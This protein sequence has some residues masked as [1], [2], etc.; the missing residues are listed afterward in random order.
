MKSIN[1]QEVLAYLE[2]SGASY[3]YENDPSP[4]EITRIKKQIK[5]SEERARVIA[6]LTMK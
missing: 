4:E 3:T 1:I 6:G 5:A 2:K